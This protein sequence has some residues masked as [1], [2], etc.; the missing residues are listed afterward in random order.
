MKFN[1]LFKNFVFVVLIFLALGGILGLLYSPLQQ[2]N[3]ISISQLVS[4]INQDKVK[5]ITVFG[6]DI[7][8]I[9][10][11]DKMAESMKESNS[12]LPEL[13]LGLGVDPEKIKKVEIS[14]EQKQ[15]S[16]WSWLFPALLY[17]I[18][19]ILI[20]G[21]FMWSMMKQTR[22]GAMQVFDFTKAR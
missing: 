18:F 3:K 21:Y 2:I 14:A 8:I 19:P 9:Y 20:I 12:V 13:L 15:E 5:K 1:P 16:V 6:D 17:G 4:D 10:T 22:P 7:Q 11:D